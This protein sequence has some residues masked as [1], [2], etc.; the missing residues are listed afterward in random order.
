[1]LVN[2]PGNS[3]A[4]APDVLASLRANLP[5]GMPTISTWDKQVKQ[6]E[7]DMEQITEDGQVI[8]AVERDS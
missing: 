3:V 1:M 2:L 5:T 8:V 7:K 4:I 6:D